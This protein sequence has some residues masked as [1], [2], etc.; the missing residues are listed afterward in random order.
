[1]KLYGWNDPW[2]DVPMTRREQ[3]IAVYIYCVANL[4]AVFL[5]ILISYLF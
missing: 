3:H 4:F 1:M 2:W 5:A